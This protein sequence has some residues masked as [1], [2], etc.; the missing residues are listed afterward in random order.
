MTGHIPPLPTC[1]HGLLTSFPYSIGLHMLP[2]QDD[3]GTCY[4]H[5]TQ[6]NSEA[7]SS[8][9][10]QENLLLCLQAPAIRP[11]P[12]QKSLLVITI[13]SQF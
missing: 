1:I 12:G 5:A 13:Y 8:L 3:R 9:S 11:H 7:A 6:S 10:A 2:Q 4:L